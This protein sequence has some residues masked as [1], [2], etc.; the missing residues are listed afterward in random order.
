[1]SKLFG[2]YLRNGPRSY[3]KG[4]FGVKDLVQPEDFP[5]VA[6]ERIREAYHKMDEWK[7]S[8]GKRS[9]S[10]DI[11]ILDDVS[12]S[13]CGIADVAEF[14]RNVECEPEWIDA[15]SRAVEEVS[16]F[17]NDANISTAFY[18]RAHSIDLAA[19][20][21]G[22]VDFEHKRVIKSMVESMHNEGVSLEPGRKE[23]LIRLQSED[24]VKSFSIVQSRENGVT[25]EGVWIR[26]TPEIM[27]VRMSMILAKRT[28][29][30]KDEILLPLNR[31]ELVSQLLGDINCRDTRQAVWEVGNQHTRETKQKEDLMHELV[32]IRR[33]M[34]SLRGYSSW[35]DYAQRESVL[36]P[37]GG[38][39]AVKRFL[40]DLWNNICPG[41]SR[42]LGILTDLNRG[43]QVEPWDMD[44]LIKL[45]RREQYPSLASVEVLQS[46]L[47][48]ARILAGG[49]RV[50]DKLFDIDLQYD[51]SCGPLWHDDAFRLS[52]SRNQGPAFAYL[53]LDA[54]ARDSKSVQSAQFTLAGSKVLPNGQRQIPQTA[55]VLS[56]PKSASGA[57]PLSVAQTFFHELGHAMH[58]LLSETSLQHFSGSRGAIDFVEFPSHL[59]EYFA[60]DP[61]CVRDILAGE[62]DD[63]YIDDYAR[64]RNPF[65]HIEA[66]QQLTY[67][68]VD[69]VYYATGSPQDIAQYLPTNALVD[70]GKLLDILQPQS[71]ANFEHLVHYGGSYYTYLLSRAL[72]ADIW[73]KAFR[74]AP[75]S[76]ETGARLG[77]F[78]KRGSVDQSLEAIY[79][80]AA[81]LPPES[82]I[83]T[84][85]FLADLRS[86]SL[87][88]SD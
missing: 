7:I 54:Y 84:D 59:F 66:A 23:K 16:A 64:N 40:I 1:M 69:Q 14:I 61:K 83:C 47:S 51:R 21:D 32:H 11:G 85:S 52:L 26:N 5:R 3:Q 27:K 81:T 33:D 8:V 56:I 31:P 58:S 10:E 30:G 65:A 6:A 39:A 41:L 17:M 68:L 86:C 12:N 2:S 20:V 76:R 78:L 80:I 18:E 57:L 50:V 77:Q 74:A 87:I 73:H 38:P 75:F 55:L 46:K 43:S 28:N 37:I 34:A 79:S 82:R 72:A 53:Y 60:T 36:S 67:A 25:N 62:V 42:E 13:L 9:P 29:Q 4:L 63:S 70:K 71:V 22:S 48:F 88:H 35:N 49:Q 24:V 45:W 44:Y 15:A 19:D